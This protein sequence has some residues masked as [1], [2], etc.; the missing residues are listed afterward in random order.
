MAI[1]LPEIGA[2]PFIRSRGNSKCAQ[3]FNSSYICHKTAPFNHR[4]YR[5]T[6]SRVI[7]RNVVS[8]WRFLTPAL[9]S[10][11]DI[12]PP[13]FPR[14]N[15]LGQ[16]YYMTSPQANYFANCNKVGKGLPYRTGG[17]NYFAFSN[18]LVTL[19]TFNPFTPV[20]FF[21]QNV[22]SVPATRRFTYWC[23]DITLN[24]TTPEFPHGYKQIKTFLPGSYIYF[25]LTTEFQAVY[26]Q[27]NT[28]FPTP[29][30]SLYIHCALQELQD[31]TG[32][33]KILN[34]AFAKFN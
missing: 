29:A 7:F 2:D 4:T 23:T 22:N 15:S 33:T 26:G 24:S 28:D 8:K 6:Y 3:N 30:P 17:I 10:S 18:R 27:F 14:T 21:P 12:T 9:K 32:A 20:L 16:T 31:T 1:Y 25:D 34:Y 19:G 11:W 5:Q 13:Q